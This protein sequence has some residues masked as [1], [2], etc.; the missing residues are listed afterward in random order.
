MT[1]ALLR[2]KRD[3]AR[4]YVRY[5]P[6][7]VGKSAML[8]NYLNAELRDHPVVRQARTRFG[9]TFTTDTQETC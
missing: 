3:L 8:D 6:G 4:W 7:V 2:F 9:A 1:A 5:A